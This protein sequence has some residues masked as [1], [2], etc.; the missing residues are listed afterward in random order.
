MPRDELQ[1]LHLREMVLETIKVID[2]EENVRLLALRQLY[3]TQMMAFQQQL[4]QQMSLNSDSMDGNAMDEYQFASMNYTPSIPNPIG[5]NDSYSKYT[6]YPNKSIISD[7]ETYRPHNSIMKSEI[8]PIT[9]NSHSQSSIISGQYHMLKFYSKQHY[10]YFR[11]YIVKKFINNKL[12]FLNK[13]KTNKKTTLTKILPSISIISSKIKNQQQDEQKYI[14][15]NPK[16]NEDGVSSSSKYED[17]NNKQTTSSNIPMEIDDD[18]TNEIRMFEEKEESSTPYYNP[19][20]EKYKSLND[21]LAKKYDPESVHDDVQE[22]NDENVNTLQQGK[23]TNSKENQEKS[24]DHIL[25]ES[26]LEKRVRIKETINQNQIENDQ[27]QDILKAHHQNEIVIYEDQPTSMNESICLSTQ[28]EIRKE[29]YG[30]FQN[31]PGVSNSEERGGNSSDNEEDDQ[32]IEI[33]RAPINFKNLALQLDALLAKNEMVGKTFQEKN[34]NNI[35]GKNENE[36]NVND[37]VIEDKEENSHENKNENEKNVHDIIIEDKEDNKEEDKSGLKEKHNEQEIIFG[38]DTKDDDVK[39]NKNNKENLVGEEKCNIKDAIDKKNEALQENEDFLKKELFNKDNQKQDHELLLT[40]NENKDNQKQE[41]ELL[42][43]NNEN[44]DNQKQDNE[45]LLTN[46]ENKDIMDSDIEEEPEE[47]LF[48]EEE[49]D[50]SRNNDNQY[51]HNNNKDDIDIN[52]V[53]ISSFGF[54]IAETVTV[55]PFMDLQS[56]V[57]SNELLK[58]QIINDDLG[59]KLKVEDN[60][61]IG[62]NNHNSLANELTKALS[63]SNGLDNGTSSGFLQ[64]DDQ[65]YFTQLNNHLSYYQTQSLSNDYDWEEDQDQER[66]Q[67]YEIMKKENNS[68]NIPIGNEKIESSININKTLEA[69]EIN[70]QEKEAIPDSSQSTEQSFNQ[71][72]TTITSSISDPATVEPTLPTSMSKRDQLMLDHLKSQLAR[73][74]EA[75]YHFGIFLLLAYQ[76]HPLSKRRHVPYWLKLNDALTTWTHELQGWYKKMEGQLSQNNGK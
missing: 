68:I 8:L 36:K 55:S 47:K 72:P 22:D 40:N 45:L 56:Q 1:C 49:I 15:D 16:N 3:Q 34:E 17:K 65:A 29:I 57:F 59:N 50:H 64:G 37:I 2:I 44:K 19:M 35:E 10:H 18:L 21:L 46:N 9:N 32:E 41:H 14:I 61:I 7:D 26:L 13:K 33:S 23:E 74:R 63:F 75:C 42:L 52:A 70:N 76:Y 12:G 43:T 5:T 25:Q 54:P 51:S 39:R 38:K 6:Q 48:D 73:S 66:E 60:H 20:T 67:E 31:E 30:E 62:D 11:T 69:N 28:E 24:K 53:R 27:V 71:H 58:G 4:L